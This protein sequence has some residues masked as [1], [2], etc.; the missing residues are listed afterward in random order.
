[1][2]AFYVTPSNTDYNAIPTGYIVGSFADFVTNNEL[3]IVEYTDSGA[4][5]RA[6]WG[7][8]E[9][10][11]TYEVV[12]E[13]GQEA[14]P[15]EP[16][17]VDMGGDF[18]GFVEA[19]NAPEPLFEDESDRATPQALIASLRN[20]TTSW[21]TLPMKTVDGVEVRAE[22]TRSTVGG[23]L[24]C[25]GALCTKVDSFVAAIDAGNDLV[26]AE[27]ERLNKRDTPRV[28]QLR[29]RIASQERELIDL[30]FELSQLLEGDE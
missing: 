20:A 9:G 5:V 19:V 4:I 21:L 1:M 28:K 3:E 18:D 8:G 17:A 23:Y 25:I 7:N 14:H 24:V 6:E 30:R 13:T 2:S 11:D 16:A 22:I 26:R 12:F 10:W 15:D 27:V 29:A